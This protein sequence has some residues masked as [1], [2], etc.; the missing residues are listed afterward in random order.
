MTEWVYL[1]GA[2]LIEVASTLA[3]RAAA[4]GRRRW[5]ALVVP[6]Y[7]ASFSLLALAL[8]AGLGIGVAYGVWT[9]VGV[10]LTAILSHVLFGEALTRTMVVGIVL[11]AAGVVLLEAG[12]G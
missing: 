6:G 11:I 2:I 5:Y 10:A 4:A 12:G 3:L 9:A 7:V 1:A 8:D